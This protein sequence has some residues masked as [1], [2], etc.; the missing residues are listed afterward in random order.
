VNSIVYFQVII[1]S[2][3]LFGGGLSCA[4][5]ESGSPGPGA[6]IADTPANASYII[7]NDRVQLDNG[8]AEWQAAP[9]SSSKIKIALLGET[10]YGALNNDGD[11][12][13]VIFLTYQ[14]GG[15]G[16]FI[17]LGAALLENGNYRGTN[18]V[19]LGDRIGQPTANIKNG[20]IT[21]SYLG[22][23]P[24]EG[25]ATTPSVE[26]TRYFI[27]DHS[28]LRE[29][30]PAAD[31]IVHQGWLTIGHEVRS[32]LPCDGKDELWLKGDS[33]ALAEIITAYRETMTDSPTYTPVFTVLTGK[34]TIPD[35]EG[36]G[37]EYKQALSSSRL[38]HIWPEGNCRSNLIILNSPLP[39]AIISSPLTIKGRARGTW[40]FEGDFPII[41]EDGQGKSIAVSYATA[42]GEWMT[43]DFV[44][45]E[46][47]INFKGSLSGQKGTLILK[48]D[49]PT[50]L[51][52]F[53][54][55]LEI[56]IN[57]N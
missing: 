6:L 45:F 14:G 30:K 16:T 50:G 39:G 33:Q 52:K 47:I 7:G 56:S 13:A 32:F 21:I 57:F 54:D 20:L 5:P 34:R 51:P 37:A 19:W 27:L 15:S 18:G 23:I 8:R 4:K 36:F 10:V 43:A 44:D 40:F 17:Y 28:T 55:S 11:G 1:V 2:L 48:K 38:I 42:K 26:Q 29:I 41:L 9:G 49:N 53:D 24:D 35:T 3:L 31:E 25:M 22:R 12:D 46:G